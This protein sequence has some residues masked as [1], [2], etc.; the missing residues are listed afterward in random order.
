ME[1]HPSTNSFNLTN[2]SSADLHRMVQ[3]DDMPFFLTSNQ[4]ERIKELYGKGHTFDAI[5]KLKGLIEDQGLPKK[6]FL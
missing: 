5:R 1:R 4:K 2:F 3:N 6:T